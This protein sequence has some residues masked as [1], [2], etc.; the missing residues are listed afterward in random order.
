MPKATPDDM[1]PR[2]LLTPCAIGALIVR[3][4]TGGRAPALPPV[5]RYN[6]QIVRE[7]I[8]TN[9]LPMVVR[10]LGLAL[11]LCAPPLIG[12]GQDALRTTNPVYTAMLNGLLKQT[13]PFVSAAQ[14]HAEAPAVLLDARAPREFAVSHLRGARWVGFEEFNLA[15]VQDLPRNTPIVVYCS[16]GYRSE[17]VGELRWSN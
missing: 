5:A 10:R 11:L 8:P 17:K 9:S 12:R 2:I 13:V 1:L 15:R 7:A 16:V 14:L 3:P 6:F 4:A